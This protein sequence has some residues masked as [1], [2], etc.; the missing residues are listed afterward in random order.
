MFTSR[1]LL[2]SLVLIGPWFAAAWITLTVSNRNTSCRLGTQAA[3]SAAEISVQIKEIVG[4]E[5]SIQKASRFM[6]DA[7]WLGNDLVQLSKGSA[8]SDQ[9]FGLLVQEQAI[10]FTATYGEIMGQRLLDAKLVAA[11]DGGEMLGLV[12]LEVCLLDRTKQNILSAET[13]EGILKNAV[14]SLGPKQRRQYKNV[15]AQQLA[16][17]LLSPDQEAVFCLC[18]LAVSPNA[19]RHGVGAKLC[20]VAETQAR[21]WDFDKVY[22]KVETS[23]L[24]AR[25]LYEDKF[26]YEP[27]YTIEND[28]AIRVDLAEGKFVETTAET[29]ILVKDV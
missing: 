12:G 22:L 6:V 26:G 4:D 29:I 15:P 3:M 1:R 23:N 10:G 2:V 19:R 25:S 7:F 16:Q 28:L 5:E 14:A 13:S 18:N 24:A 21:E 9:A 17:E 27:L 11:V 20:E 8:L